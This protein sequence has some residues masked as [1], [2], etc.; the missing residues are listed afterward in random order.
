MESFYGAKYV[1]GYVASQ[2][3][4]MHFD[5]NIRRTHAHLTLLHVICNESWLLRVCGF[6]ATITDS[7]T[8]EVLFPLFFARLFTLDALNMCT[9]AAGK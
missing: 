8:N 7:H 5:L 4:S 2:S 1:C 6:L 3:L 9:F